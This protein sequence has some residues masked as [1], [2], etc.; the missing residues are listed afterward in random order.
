MKIS[1]FIQHDKMPRLFE[2]LDAGLGNALLQRLP[3]AWDGQ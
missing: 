3:L 1:G 2:P